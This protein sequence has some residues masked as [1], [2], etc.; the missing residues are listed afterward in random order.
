MENLEKPGNIG[1]ILRTAS[2]IGVDAVFFCDEKIDLYNPNI[3]RSSLGSVFNNN[4]AIS[5][6]KSIISWLKKKQIKIFPTSVRESAQRLYNIN[7]KNIPLAIVIGQEKKGLSKVWFKEA[8][9]IIQ[10][11]I[12]NK[13]IDSL[14]VSN[15]TAI[16]LFEI[17]RQK[18]FT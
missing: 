3:V 7:F 18:C 10:I 5:N 9:D 16:I 15:A 8:S 2:A 11:P 12:K 14:N 6:T 1:A 4:I 13:Y 17:Y